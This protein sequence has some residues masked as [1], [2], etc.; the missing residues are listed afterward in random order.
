MNLPQFVQIEPVGQCNL[1]CKMCPVTFREEPGIAGEPVRPPAFMSYE[2][3]C[4][5]ID[6]F[7]GMSELHLQEIGRA[8]V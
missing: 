3:F 4:R 8:H 7:P 2:V 1:A 5:L 6:Q